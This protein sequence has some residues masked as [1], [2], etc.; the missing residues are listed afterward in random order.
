M[1]AGRLEVFANSG[2]AFVM[3]ITWLEVNASF[4]HSS[5]AL[6][7]LHM[8]CEAR[9]IQAHWSRVASAAREDPATVAGKVWQEKPDVLITSLYLF[10]RLQVLRIL[11][12][13]RVLLP[14]CQIGAGGPEC[15]GNNEE[16][17]RSTPALDLAFRG[18]GELSL[19]DWLL[20]A[21]RRQQWEGVRGLCW[22][23]DGVYR[24][25]GHPGAAPPPDPLTLV[26]DPFFEFAK[27]F[28]QL[29]TTRG[30]PCRC[31][32]CTSG[33]EPPTGSVSLPRLEQA[34]RVVRQHGVREVRILDRTFNAQPQR[35]RRL[36]ELFT[37]FPDM[38][39]HLEIHPG[40]LTNSL[41]RT[42]MSLPEGLVHLEAGVQTF[43]EASLRLCDRNADPPSVEE[44]VRGLA[45]CPGLEVHADLLAG[46]PGQEVAQV[47]RDLGVLA[48][49]G[50]AEIQLEIL[51]VLPGT[52]LRHQAA[53]R[54][55]LF[56]PDT[57]YEVLSTETMNATD[58]EEVRLL[59][60]TVDRYYNEPALRP[61]TRC[62]C[63]EVSVFRQFLAWLRRYDRADAPVALQRRF[64]FLY[65]YLHDSRR[66]ALAEQLEVRWLQ[67]GLSP[68]RGLRPARRWKK[69]IPGGVV[70]EDVCGGLPAAIEGQTWYLQQPDREWWF[71][72]DRSRQ[73]RMP[74][75]VLHRPL[76][77]HG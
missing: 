1:T 34:L 20:C 5:L 69:P 13:V 56:A 40:Y 10:N 60:K 53:S 4:A 23:D 24:D 52:G 46:L 9:G 43:Q 74:V 61:V 62:L 63:R 11:R 17:L 72:Y 30:C 21:G 54:G 50:P 15:L 32:F 48:A 49:A 18:A 59:A 55:V 12:R 38:R 6:P 67:A 41:R 31:S 26:K 64:R 22:L 33:C 77:A 28:V 57:P 39:F 58:L 27:P 14:D 73:Q 70:S 47:Y 8:A 7:V 75:R 51:K 44:S 16:L 19:P 76:Q 29:E 2:P 37:N 35:C 45:E 65:D 36:L 42:L 71:V 66:T 68:R 3:N 25:N